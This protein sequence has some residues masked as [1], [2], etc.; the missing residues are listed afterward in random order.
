ML[1]LVAQEPSLFQGTS[2]CDGFYHLPR[3]IEV[4]RGKIKG[5]KKKKKANR[6][7]LFSAG[8]IR[9]NILLGVDPSQ[10]S[11]EQLHQVCRDANI[12]DFIV[13]LPEGY[14]TKIGSRG[15]SLSGGQKQ[16][17]SIARALV[18]NPRVLLLD[19]AT[20]SLD[21]GTFLYL[22]L[23]LFPVRGHGLS[24]F[25]D[26]LLWSH[27]L[28]LNRPLVA[29]SEKLV[30]AAFERVS[31]GR[32]TVAVAHRLATIQNADV[33]YVLG[34]G[35]VLEK[36]S[37]TELLKRKGVYFHMVRFVF[38]PPSLPSIDDRRSRIRPSLYST[39]TTLRNI[40]WKRSRVCRFGRA[41]RF[42][43]FSLGF[44]TFGGRID[45]RDS[46]YRYPFFIH[47]AGGLLCFGG[48]ATSLL[49]ICV[50]DHV[51]PHLQP[52]HVY[53]VR[54]LHSSRTLTLIAS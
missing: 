54:H 45:K 1:S 29:E 32:T 33:I 20:S 34:E 22:C 19:E 7:A 6:H 10:V 46:M 47:V 12:H 3:T 15:V 2:L 21:S 23:F 24:I 44:P 42:V 40:S 4:E 36:G 28:L 17:L 30:Q 26:A 37:H 49:C 38:F 18:R 13:S 43:R 8:T 52:S 16:R 5:E 31:K 51:F 14:E 50:N 35:K 48:A 9:E 39:V 11:E 25:P 41:A 27:G 53:I